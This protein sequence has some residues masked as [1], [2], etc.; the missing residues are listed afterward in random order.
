[1]N[2]III[3]FIIALVTSCIPKSIDKNEGI[4]IIID[5]KDKGVKNTHIIERRL[6]EFGLKDCNIIVKDN[7][8]VDV[9][10]P[11]YNDTLV[12]RKLLSRKGDFRIEET[13]SNPEIY[14]FLVKI[15][16][17]MLLI[18]NLDTGDSTDST[19]KFPFYNILLPN[20]NN[21]GR[22][23][24]SPIIGYS[25]L[26]DT[27]SVMLQ[28]DKFKGIIPSDL[29][30]KWGMPIQEDL[31][32]LI[33][34]RKLTNT[35]ITS[36]MIE[37]SNISEGFLENTF[38]VNVK[39]KKEFH[40]NL[41][42]LSRENIGRAISIIID[43][44]VYSYPKVQMEIN[45]GIASISGIYDYNEGLLMSSFLNSGILDVKILDMKLTRR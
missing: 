36:N 20:V 3:I 23:I 6:K 24:N 17:R 10:I 27:N 18:Q 44:K 2:K 19:E 41:L 7:G 8:I 28:F 25:K 26:N 31:F 12:I 16:E 15:N 29:V 22:V 39:L 45:G 4:V 13:Y 40:N 9:E 14:E 35:P 42:V 21:E 5:L 43:N 11:D 30:V 38:E 33:A 32:P 1:M 37:S 34:I